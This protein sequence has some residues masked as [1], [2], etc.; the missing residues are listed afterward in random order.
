MIPIAILRRNEMY[1]YVTQIILKI[2]LILLE[3]RPNKQSLG[4]H[5]TQ[6]QLTKTKSLDELVRLYIVVK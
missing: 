1:L 4:K 3:L 2:V 5:K 6:F